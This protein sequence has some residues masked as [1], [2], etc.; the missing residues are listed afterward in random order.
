MSDLLKLN[1]RLFDGEGGTGGDAGVSGVPGQETGDL[2]AV[3]YGKQESQLATDNQP[4]DADKEF[5]ELINGK[6]KD[7]Y[8]K[9][10]QDTIQ[11]RLKSTNE[12]VQRYNAISP[13]LEVL[14]NKYGVDANDIQ[15]LTDAIND[16]DSYWEDEALEKGITVEQ[17]KEIKAIE[18][19]NADLKR[20]MREQETQEQADKIYAEWLENAEQIKGI[21]PGFDLESELQ[22]PQ[23][24][25]LLRNNVDMKAAYEVLHMHEIIPAAM[26]FT[27]KSVESKLTNKI[28]SQGSR[29]AEN[30]INSQASSL[31]RSDVSRLSKADRAEIARRVQRGERIV[32]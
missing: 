30:G 20:Q 27:A 1:L 11:R 3:Q 12:T 32:F 15:A 9:R 10:V 26:Q 23:F 14:G 24:V 31:V 6:F 25:N 8:G 21:Y 4:I 16:D 17:L 29:P 13:I 2:S 5:E 28:R 7:Q 19:E 18:R 22:N